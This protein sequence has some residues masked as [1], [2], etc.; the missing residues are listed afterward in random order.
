MKNKFKIVS[1]DPERDNAI[2]TSIIKKL[3]KAQKI[4]KG[5]SFY[6]GLFDEEKDRNLLTEKE[7]DLWMS[8]LHNSQTCNDNCTGI[9][10][11][12]FDLIQ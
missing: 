7:Y 1:Y 12:R 3:D 5:T 8:I 10:K 2:L 11:W 6:T 9:S 4:E